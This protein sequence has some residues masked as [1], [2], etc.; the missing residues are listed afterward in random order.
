MIKITIKQ[1][2]NLKYNGDIKF[3]FK[4][5]MT[6]KEALKILTDELDGWSNVALKRIKKIII[7]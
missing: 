1:D 3:E 6:P 4:E 2:A 7:S 5:E